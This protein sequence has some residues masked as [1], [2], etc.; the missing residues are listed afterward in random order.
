MYTELPK[1]SYV[2]TKHQD[3]HRMNMIL[4]SCKWVCFANLEAPKSN[5]PQDLSTI[6]SLLFS[7][8]RNIATLYLCPI[9]G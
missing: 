9:S 6:V 7:R 4:K 5:H 3:K 1:S 8:N 2:L